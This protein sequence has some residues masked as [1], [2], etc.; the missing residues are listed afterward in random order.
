MLVG[1]I[2]SRINLAIY[3]DRQPSCREDFMKVWVVVGEDRGCGFSVEGVFMNEESA[4][5]AC[6]SRQYVFESEILD[7][8]GNAQQ[9]VQADSSTPNSLT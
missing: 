9:Q 1:R 3:T 8:Q 6:L 4:N 5:S 2:A 7:A